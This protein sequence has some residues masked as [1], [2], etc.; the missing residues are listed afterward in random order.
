[1]LSSRNIVAF[2]TMTE[3]DD[4][5]GKTRSCHVYV[6]DLNMSWHA[7]KVLSN[8]YN[9][10]ALEWDL[11]DDKLTDTAGNVQWMF[12]DRILNDW[13]LIGSAYFPGEHILGVA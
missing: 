12:K 7:H 11:S 1:V 4:S 13:I 8:K 3:L 10:T 9:I 6:A 2:I 5:S